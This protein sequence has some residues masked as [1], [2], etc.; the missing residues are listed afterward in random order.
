MNIFEGKINESCNIWQGLT[1]H[2]TLHNQSF[3]LVTGK[4]LGSVMSMGAHLQNMLDN[5]SVMSD[6]RVNR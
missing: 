4:S 1:A 2:T 3:G 5:P 6:P